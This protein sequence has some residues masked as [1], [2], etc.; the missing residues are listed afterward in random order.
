MTDFCVTFLRNATAYGPSPRMRF[1]IVLNDLVRPGL[2]GEE[3]RDDQRR[4]PVAADRARRGHL[5]RRFAARSTRR[6]RRSTAR[7]STSDA[8]ARTTASARSRRSSP[9]C[10]RAARSRPDRRARTIAA[11]GCRFDKIATELPGF[12]SRWTARRGAEELRRC[13]NA[14]S[15]T[16]DITVPRLHAPEAAEVPARTG[17]IDDDLACAGRRTSWSTVDLSADSHR[18]ARMSN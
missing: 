6:S 7:S 17:Q 5:S 18:R 8:F 9:M 2:D 4:Q 12:Q 16:E 14:S 15:S 13:S 1:D 3:D 10:F 11:T